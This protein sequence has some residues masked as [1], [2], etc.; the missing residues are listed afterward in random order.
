MKIK[1]LLVSMGAV[2][3]LAESG[4]P[5]N[6]QDLSLTLDGGAVTL[7]ATNVTVD[8]ILARWSKTTG[9]TVV[10]QNGHGSDVPVTVHVSGVTEREAL[11][12]VLRSLSGYIMGERRD[13]QT[14]AVS[15]D[16]LVILPDSA[17]R[18]SEA[19]ALAR[20]WPVPA[21]P[22]P[23][24]VVQPVDEEPTELAPVVDAPVIDGSGEITEP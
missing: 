1:V 15:I 20:R 22:A 13:P 19:P 23:V 9:L 4:S 7:H 10:S 24:E 16:R 12:L 14:G 11:G 21:A 2:C 5:A 18:A 6:A 3:C 8:E 17:A